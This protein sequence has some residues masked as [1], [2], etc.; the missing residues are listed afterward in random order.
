MSNVVAPAFRR[1]TGFLLAALGRRTETA[2]S[3]FL[4]GHSLSNAEFNALAVLVDE[5]PGQGQL[6]AYLAIDP[7][8]VGALVRKLEERGWAES[9]PH[10][11][12][13]RR[14]II[15]ITEGGRSVW[16]S[17]QAALAT[18]RADYF[19]ALDP[20]ERREL[21]RLLNKLNDAHL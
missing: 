1:R 2:W 8:N 16:A 10:P 4:R 20:E 14:R 15:E 21:E 9:K 12:D 3:A 5:S 19:D 17:V 13:A 6:A 11:A 7:R 18:A